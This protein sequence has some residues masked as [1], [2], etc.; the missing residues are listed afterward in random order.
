MGVQT[1]PVHVHSGSFTQ[2][3]WFWRAQ[4]GWHRPELASQRQEVSA[5]QVLSLKYRYWHCLVHLPVN[6]WHMDTV[7]H[8]VLV[9]TSVQRR[10]QRPRLESHSQLGSELQSE[11][12]T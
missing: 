8:S 6:H 2:D 12:I 11:L 1:V 5:L 3:A 9:V 7:P 4:L 10:S